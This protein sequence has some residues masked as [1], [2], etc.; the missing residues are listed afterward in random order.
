VLS[1]TC[2]L[3]LGAQA[4][5]VAVESD[6][7]V[8]GPTETDDVGLEPVTQTWLGDTEAP[9]DLDE[10]VTE[11]LALLV[12]HPRAVATHDG[13]EKDSTRAGRVLDGKVTLTERDPSCRGDRARVPD[14]QFS[15]HHE[16]NL[17]GPPHRR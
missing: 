6:E 12:V 14:F 4:E 16:E 7:S 17:Q 13:G 1:G 11:V 2:V 9:L 15:E 5:A 10:E 3:A 8:P